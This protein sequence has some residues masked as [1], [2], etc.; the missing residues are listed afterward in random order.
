MLSGR[1]ACARAG[2]GG[3]A[4]PPRKMTT[5]LLY[6]DAKALDIAERMIAEAVAN[7]EQKQKQREKQREKKRDDKSRNRQLY[8]LRHTKVSRAAVGRV[9]GVGPRRRAAPSPCGLVCCWSRR[10]AGLRGARGAGG[11]EPRRHQEGLPQARAPGQC[12]LSRALAWP[13]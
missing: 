4:P 6:G 2:K 1:A 9:G 3:A 12:A 7:R 11:H 13:P 10:C 5:L 8:I